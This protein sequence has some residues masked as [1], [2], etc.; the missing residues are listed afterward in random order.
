MAVALV[1]WMS[2]DALDNASWRPMQQG[3][4]PLPLTHRALSHKSVQTPTNL[5]AR[6]AFI[7]LSPTP[8]T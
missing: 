5:P 3:I 1:V 4:E 6:R 8:I 7:L 2:Y